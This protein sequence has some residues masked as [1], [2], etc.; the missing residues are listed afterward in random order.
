M[1]H[2]SHSE[3]QRI[4]EE[5]AFEQKPVSIAPYGAGHINRTFLVTCE[6]GGR[7]LLQR[8]SEGL[9]K[10]A[11]GL[12]DNIDRVIRHLK[13]KEQDPRK[14]MS[15]LA[16]RDG[17]KFL[18]DPTGNWRV[19]YFIEDSICLQKAETDED[20]YQTA[21][22][23]GHFEEL[24]TD[25]PAD[26]LKETIVDFHNTPM[27]CAHF[28]RALDA[29]AVHRCKE[30]EEEIAF[31]LAR[32][33]EMGMLQRMRDAGQLPVRVTH[34]DTKLNN[35]LFDRKTRK[36][37]CVIDL[38]TVMPGLSLYDFGDAIRFGA[39]TAAEDEKDFSRMELDLHK[40]RIFLEGFRKACPGLTKEEIRL[41]PA[42][43]KIITLEQAVRFLADYLE[44]DVYY[45]T[46]YPGQNLDRARTQIR[47]AA[48]MEKKW[49]QMQVTV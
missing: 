31:L 5:F 26:T 4:A 18:A 10:D 22:A 37:L 11:E 3:L 27:R 47:L 1:D 17:K 24:L 39:A 12:M 48:D 14:V 2:M 29:D 32:E 15:L 43:A 23:F 6:D 8:I 40:Y 9:T 30:V 7:F 13:S 36:A 44:G 34:N 45:H 28:H 42:G 46:S 41:L 25:F 38:D 21:L 19:Y 33:E 16:A 20:F 49:E 35:V